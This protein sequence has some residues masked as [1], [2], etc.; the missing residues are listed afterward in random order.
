[1]QDYKSLFVLLFVVII[2]V[3]M[4]QG[5]SDIIMSLFQLIL[6]WMNIKITK[7]N[8]KTSMLNE[9]QSSQ[10][11]GFQTT[12]DEEECE[13]DDEENNS[14][15]NIIEGKSNTK[16]CLHTIGFKG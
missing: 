10:A 7:N 2:G 13:D 15:D 3:P 6:S 16:C 12:D 1:M 14:P 9:P 11:I 4:L 5:I 8:I